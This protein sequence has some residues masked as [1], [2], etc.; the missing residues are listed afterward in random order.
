MVEMEV[1]KKKKM[2]KMMLKEKK[3]KEEKVK[4]G[5]LLCKGEPIGW[6]PVN[7]EYLGIMK[8]TKVMKV[9]KTIM[10]E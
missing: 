5:A 3:K 4:S 9:M 8:I 7:D 2:I 6:P 1:I 10:G